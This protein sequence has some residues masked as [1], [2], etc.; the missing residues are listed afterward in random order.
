MS[1][2]PE[3][4]QCW[5]CGNNQRTTG[6][7]KLQVCDDCLMEMAATLCLDRLGIG[8]GSVGIDRA[9]FLQQARRYTQ[10]LFSRRPTNIRRPPF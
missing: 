3:T 7:P 4:W 6:L 5:T 1:D 2:N 8:I 9:Y 10:R